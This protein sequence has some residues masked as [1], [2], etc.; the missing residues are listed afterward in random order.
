MTLRPVTLPELL[1]SRDRR[2]ARQQQWLRRE[3]SLLVLTIVM[4]GNVKRD[5]LSL[6]AAEAAVGGLRTAFQ[7]H[8]LEFEEFDLFTGFEA[9]ARIA[10][11]PEETKRIACGIEDTHPLGRLFD[12]DV[13]DPQGMPLSR[14]TLGIAP[15]KCLMCDNDAR[16]CM[17]SG[18]HSYTDLRAHIASMINHYHP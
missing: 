18:A 5:E 13:I 9:F 11:T 1:E 8:I 15:R 10:L 12:I 7:N 6:A 4:P 16:V 2:R 14:T 3:G 17:R